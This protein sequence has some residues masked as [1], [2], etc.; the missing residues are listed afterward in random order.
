MIK[1]LHPLAGV[2]A[3]LTIITFWLSTVSSEL[4]GSTATV[5]AVKTS[6]P[7]GFLL[8]VPA[9][10][11]TGATGFTLAK[12]WRAGLVNTKIRRMPL[13]AANGLF[14]LIPAALF[15]AS[16]ARISEFDAAFYT[17]QAL[18]LATGAAN[19]VL[20]GLNMRDG[21]RMKNRLRLRKT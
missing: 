17:V 4:F 12:G 20:L 6:I 18:E 13:I 7:W 14:I 1:N 3:L 21:L 9:L 5:I 15:L 11:L 19:I 8:L 16:K 10:A 2:L